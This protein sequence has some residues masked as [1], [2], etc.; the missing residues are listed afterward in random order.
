MADG[1]ETHANKRRDQTI[2]MTNMNK[3]SFPSG[4]TV[5]GEKKIVIIQ[6]KQ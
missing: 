5:F 1:N 6:N 4:F 3:L 2:N